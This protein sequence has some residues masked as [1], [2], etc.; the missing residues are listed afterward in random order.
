MPATF[1]VYLTLAGRRVVVVGGGPV[2][3]RKAAAAAAA[4]A[5]VRVVSLGPRPAGF[6]DPGVGWL[7]EPYRAGHLDGAML[8]FACG[9]PAVNAAVVADAAARGVWACDAADPGRGTFVLPAVARAG[10]LTVAVGTGGASP[11]LARRL[12]EKLRAE[13]DGAV[14][15]WADLLAE[16]RAVSKA[17]IPDP[18]R[19]RAVLDGLAD[20][21]WLDRLRRDGPAATRAAMRE[22][23]SGGGS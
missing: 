10:R 14:A 16:M 18:A 11:A 22:T 21:P 12:A 19:R 8:A 3:R 17:A 9:P 20:W 5:A 15:D 23:F 6:D 7:A 1:P 4:G 2:G 13:F